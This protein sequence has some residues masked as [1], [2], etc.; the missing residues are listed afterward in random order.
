MKESGPKY[1][2]LT[3]YKAQFPYIIYILLQDTV[4]SLDFM[5]SHVWLISEQGNEKDEEGSSFNVVSC[6]IPVLARRNWG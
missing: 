6:T 1:K 4:S 5:T 3:V 2:T